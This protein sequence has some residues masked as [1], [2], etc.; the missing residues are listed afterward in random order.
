M[1][2]WTCPN[3]GEKLRAEAGERRACGLCGEVSTAPGAPDALERETAARRLG[4]LGQLQQQ[5]A[6]TAPEW[7]E[8]ADLHREAGDEASARRAE[9]AAASLDA[10]G[11]YD[12]R[13]APAPM[14]D[15]QAEDRS[16]ARTVAWLSVAFGVLGWYYSLISF[17][18]FACG[19]AVI[20]EYR[21]G[22]AP[23]RT[24]LVGLAGLL[25]TLFPLSVVVL[26]ILRFFV[27]I[28]F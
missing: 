26:T 17:V 3:C 21:R 7:R 24:A 20:V 19:W 10:G 6:L 15:L 1:T 25:V 14:L 16:I 22:R 18:G 4:E 12:P 11:A 13:P 27:P 5:R 9:A 23:A 8:C 2:E 28:G